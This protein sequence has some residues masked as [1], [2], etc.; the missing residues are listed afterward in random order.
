MVIPSRSRRIS[1][2]IFSSGL[3]AVQLGG[4][5][6]ARRSVVE[7]E[8]RNTGP[9]MAR[10][11]SSALMS[12]AGGP[13]GSR[14]WC[15]APPPESP[16]WSAFAA[17]WRAA[18]RA[19]RGRRRFPW[20]WRSGHS[21]HGKVHEG[22]QSVVGF[23]AEPE[24]GVRYRTY[25]VLY[26][27][28][29]GIGVASRGWGSGLDVAGRTAN[30][31]RR[32]AVGPAGG[33]GARRTSAA[34]RRAE[35]PDRK[36]NRLSYFGMPKDGCRRRARLHFGCC[37]KRVEEG[38]VCFR[39]FAGLSVGLH[40]SGCRACQRD[41]V[42]VPAV[43]GA[44]RLPDRALLGAAGGGVGRRGSH[45]AAHGGVSVAVPGPGAGACGGQ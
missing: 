28:Y 44:A 8:V 34:A 45:R 18:A 3:R 37:L 21:R 4:L 40:R 23:F 30:A 10:I 11:T 33:G 39:P 31:V 5:I 24:H 36:R 7:Q 13:A 12:P 27:L 22:D 43:S 17:L 26:R 1:S 20:R 19:G 14:R 25:P 16:P 35:E 15:R 29:L 9:S 6:A 2:R 32:A 41:R 38:R 42:R